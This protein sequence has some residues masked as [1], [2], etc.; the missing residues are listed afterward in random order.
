[1]NKLITFDFDGTL[2]DTST[3]SPTGMNVEQAYRLAIE[4]IFG[5][6]SRLLYDAN[7]Q[8]FA[9]MEPG[10][11]VRVLLH[12]PDETITQ[13]L[14]DAKLSH[15]LP[16]ISPEWPRLYDGV[17][18]FY[19]AVADG[20]IPV[21][22]AVVSSGHDEF[23]RRVFEVNEIPS[24]DIL[25]T[26]DNLRKVKQPRRELHKP[27]TYQLALAHNEW[28]EKNGVTSD[29]GYS[30]RGFGKA[31]MMYVGNDPIKDGG[32]ALRARVPFGFVP[33]THPDFQPDENLGQ[34]AIPS[35]T[36][37]TSTLQD[38]R[39]HLENGAGFSDILMGVSDREL[40]PPLTEA[41]RPYGVWL[42]E[43]RMQPSGKERF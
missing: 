21:D 12:R 4:E 27:F 32:L 31:H 24:P 19:E 26:S 38:N 25:I 1:M 40:F 13:R 16:L 37:L 11:M 3:P 41:Q 42:N 36:E 33:F 14:V 9:S 29:N 5:T 15:L 17:T 10:E 30:D 28:K 43:R 35:F 2:V 23:I 18:E 22:T 6:S 8:G 39:T 34:I 7:P 20:S